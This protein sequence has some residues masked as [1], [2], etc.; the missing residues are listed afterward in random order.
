[1]TTGRK[2]EWFDN[3]SFWRDLYPFM[4]PETRFAA[5]VLEVD[6]V[7]A[8]TKPKGKTVLDLCCG[9]GRCAIAL[10]KRRFSVTG[11]DRTRYLLD[12]AEAKANVA[13]VKV[14]WVQQDMRDF[15]R[16]DSFD[17][18]LSMFTSFGYF[19][20]KRDDLQ[21]LCNIFASLRPGGACLMDVVGKERLAN[22]LV[23]TTSEELAD[24]TKLIQCHEIFDDWTRIRN[25]W[26]LI[27][28][29]KA[30]SFEFHHTIYSGQELRD[31]MEQVGF[32]NVKLYG[33]L[34]GEEY[35]PNAQRLIAV[36]CK[37]G[38][39][40]NVRSR[41]TASSRRPKGRG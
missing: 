10:A 6:Q 9:P 41:T 11:V 1:M 37:P 2:R 33:N 31:R 23:P 36:G 35:G 28:Q 29:E 21:V 19:D 16:Q 26:I 22:I 5:A 38:W 25:K 4:F 39:E 8:L 40:K 24:G 15:V 34:S 20:N 3:D 14:E 13:R 30:K 18:V 27:R 12:I 32:V 7:L 17:L